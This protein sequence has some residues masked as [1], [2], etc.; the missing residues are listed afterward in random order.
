MCLEGL[1]APRLPFAPYPYRDTLS[2]WSH[3]CSILHRLTLICTP[4]RCVLKNGVSSRCDFSPPC[5]ALPWDA[6]VPHILTPRV[7]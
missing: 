4:E 5:A 3:L 1:R 6:A 2:P 7:E